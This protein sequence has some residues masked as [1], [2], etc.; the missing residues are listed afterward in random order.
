MLLPLSPLFRLISHSECWCSLEVPRS[1]SLVPLSVQHH[2]HIHNAC[3]H[4]LLKL[5]FLAP[6]CYFHLNS[7]QRS[8]G[9]S[10]ALQTGRLENCP[11]IYVLCKTD[12]TVLPQTFHFSQWKHFPYNPS[13]ASQV[14][15]K[16]CVSIFPSLPHLVK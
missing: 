3:F 9:R 16:T 15:N 5:P 11:H 6:D 12:T 13:P 4:F 8:L 10:Q 1:S 2:L 7:G 14:P